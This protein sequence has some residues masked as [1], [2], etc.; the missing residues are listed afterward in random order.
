MYLVSR[1]SVAGLS[2]NVKLDRETK[3]NDRDIKVSI[4]KEREKK[5]SS[6]DT[7]SIISRQNLGG[8]DRDRHESVRTHL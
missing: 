2:G 8:S 7:L 3:N 1:N 4:E 6:N 5:K